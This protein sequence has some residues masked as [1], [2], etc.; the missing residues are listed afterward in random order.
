MAIFERS[1]LFQSIILDIHVSFW[2]VKYIANKVTRKYLH[3]NI[4]SIYIYTGYVL[5]SPFEASFFPACGGNV[6]N[7]YL[8]LFFSSMVLVGQDSIRVNLEAHVSHVVSF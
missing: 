3:I 1:H 7:I 5:I 8:H 4:I 6:L 2:G